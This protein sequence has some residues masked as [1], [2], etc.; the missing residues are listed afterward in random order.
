MPDANISLAGLSS[1][2]TVQFFPPGQ[3][4]ST[5]VTF[6]VTDAWG[7]TISTNLNLTV[8]NTPPVISGISN[9]FTIAINSTNAIPCTVNDVESPIGSLTL[10]AFSSN[11]NLVPNGN[12]LFSGNGT[13][14]TFT[15]IPLTDQ[16]GTTVISVIITDSLGSSAT[17]QMTLNVY[18][19]TQL[20][21]TG[22]AALEYSCAAWGDY[23]NDGLFDLAMAG[24]PD[25]ISPQQTKIFHNNGN[26]KFT[27][28]NAGLLGIKVGALAWGDY[29]NDGFLDLVVTGDSGSGV[30]VTR[31][32]HNNGDGTFT[33]IN[34]GLPGFRS[35]SSVAWGDYDGD[36]KLDL[37]F[38]GWTTEPTTKIFHN[39]GGGHFSDS[40]IV[41]D[42]L[43]NGSVAWGD[44]DNDGNLDLGACGINSSNQAVT[45]VYRNDGHGHFLNANIPLTG[46][47]EGSIAWGDYDNDGHLDLLVAGSDMGFHAHSYLYRNNGNGQLIDSNAGLQGSISIGVAWGDYNNDG[48]LD[49]AFGCDDGAATPTPRLYRNSNGTYSNSGNLIKAV[50]S[51]SVSW[52]DYDN[53]GRLDLLVMGYDSNSGHNTV[54]LYQNH[55]RK[56]GNR[57]IPPANLT[58][59]VSGHLAHLSWSPSSN[60]FPSRGFTYNLRVGTSAG[61][62]NIFN[63]MSAANGWRRLPAMGN[64]GQNTNWTL[65][66]LQPGVYYW[67][68]QTIDQSFSGSAFASEGTFTIAGTTIDKPVFQP[69]GKPLIRFTGIAGAAYFIQSSTNL[70]NWTDLTN[71]SP[72][73]TGPVEFIDLLAAPPKRFYRL[74]TP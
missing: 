16:V 1:N 55:I 23:D 61:N 36:G 34:A 46:L 62:G 66:Y 24:A 44:Y 33:D 26:G 71:F 48:S 39:D 56:I 53:D 69:S 22:L 47:R 45:L 3:L 65:N 28:I 40:G 10:S 38:S 52:A 73:V 13:N 14:R 9:N 37:L 60:G 29:D 8:F 2:R 25:A 15:P 58:S 27:E 50:I 12:I 64:A 43:S 4:G 20:S 5:I 6:T 74:R 70:V 11:T 67:S 49:I 57:P 54:N 19:L 63:A 17:N 32:Y 31:I 72:L 30:A 21:G 59:V 18:E 68:V 7:G 51:G 42:G 41:L 35:N